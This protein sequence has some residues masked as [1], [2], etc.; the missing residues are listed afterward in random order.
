[1]L[2]VEL[3]PRMRAA[4]AACARRCRPV[5]VLCKETH[6]HTIRIAPPLVITAAQVDGAVGCFGDAL[7]A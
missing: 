4:P 7:R 6:E 1:M 3:H 5:G 2:A